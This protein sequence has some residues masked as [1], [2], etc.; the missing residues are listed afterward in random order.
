MERALQN[1]RDVIV[2]GGAAHGASVAWWLTKFAPELRITVIERDPTYAKAATALSVAS[3]RSQFSNPVNVEVSRFGVEF[4]RNFGMELGLESG[5]GDLGLKENGYL[6][7]GGTPDAP[8]IMAE[9][10]EMQ[11]AKGAATEV[12]SPEGLAG[13]F[14]WMNV[15]D[16]TAG[17]YG[18]R[19]EGWFDNMGLLGG[20]RQAAR[21]QGVEFLHDEAI[22][23]EMAGSRITAVKLAS[24]K[25]LACGAVINAAG[26]RGA[27]VMEW[28]GAPIPVEPRKRTVF[29]IDAPNAR[30]P[31]APLIIDHLGYYMRPEHEGWICATVPDGD[32][33]CDV[34][35]FEPEAHL[36]EDVIWP[37][38]YQRSE[39]FDAC[40]V[41]R[42]WV[43][44]YDY[45]TLD[46]NAIVGRDPR[47]D[48]LYVLNGFSGHGLQQAPAIGR[49]MA[50]LVV[51]GAYRALDLSELGVERVLDGR[52][53]LERAIV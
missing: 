38:L 13:L 40:K 12:L 9:I 14:P 21:R 43:G 30:H 27:Q 8:Q 3:V 51:H 36:F 26:T 15:E 46:Q 44:H 17:S 31:T 2:I 11:R 1:S 4:I 6:F 10:A 48:N 34:E 45:N 53:F 25:V 20:F 5:Q 28:A 23:L 35:D 49:G 32:A 52:P 47:R 50:E 42:L 39:G 29:V 7:L 22:G 16:L 24:G 33:A 41:Q 37:M 19:D 18:P